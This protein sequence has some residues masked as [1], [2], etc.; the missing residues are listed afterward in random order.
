MHFDTTIPNVR[1]GEGPCI[2]T[3]C[4]CKEF[5][6]PVL[7]IVG[8]YHMP[9]KPVLVG[10]YH[11][12]LQDEQNRTIEIAMDA[13]MAGTVDMNGLT[14]FHTT[15][16]T[17]P[18]RICK[19]CRLIYAE[20]SVFNELD[21]AMR[22]ACARIEKAKQEKAETERKQREAA[23]QAAISIKLAELAELQKEA[24]RLVLNK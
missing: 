16:K 12:P 4:S 21:D 14:A 23:V 19:H 2:R 24:A 9:E 6:L 22:K 11:A 13:Y 10:H 17:L 8:H 7:A 20:R 3:E 18:G 5:A 1:R 15:R